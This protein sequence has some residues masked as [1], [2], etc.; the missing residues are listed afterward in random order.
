MGN[1]IFNFK[2]NEEVMIE[3]VYEIINDEKFTRDLVKDTLQ[4]MIPSPLSFGLSHHHKHGFT[5]NVVRTNG[6]D[7]G[8]L[9]N[10][11]THVKFFIGFFILGTEPSLGFKI[12]RNGAILSDKYISSISLADINKIMN[13]ETDDKNVLSKMDFHS[14]FNKLSDSLKNQGIKVVYKGPTFKGEDYFEHY[15]WRF[16]HVLGDIVIY[17]SQ[18]E[19][20]DIDYDINEFRKWNLKKLV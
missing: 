3:R 8:G 5:G 4:Q 15:L 6:W 12:E 9:D 7:I 10:N 17:Q 13:N 14:R 1:I 19:V 2:F 11:V 16:E 20:I 18:E